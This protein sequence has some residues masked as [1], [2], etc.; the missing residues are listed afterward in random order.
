MWTSLFTL[1][2][3]DKRY[4]VTFYNLPVLLG[5]GVVAYAY[6]LNTWEAEAGD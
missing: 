5:I 6:I 3:H 2:A 1:L 4:L